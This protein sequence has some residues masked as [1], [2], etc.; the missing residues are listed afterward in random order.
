VANLDELV[1]ILSTAGFDGPVCVELA[2]L[3]PGEVDELA[4]IDRSVTWLKEHIAATR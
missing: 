1:S 2:S 3:G 4:M